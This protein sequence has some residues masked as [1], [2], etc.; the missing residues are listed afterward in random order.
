VTDEQFGKF[1]EVIKKLYV[2]IPLL[3]A[4]LGNKRTLPTT[5]VVQSTEKCSTA[6]LDPL[7]VNKKD[8]GCPT[9]TCS[10]G[11][12]HFSKAL[13]DLGASVSV[14]P[15]VVYDKL[16]GPLSRGNSIE[17]PSENPEFHYSHRLR[18][19]RHGSRRQDAAHPRQAILEHSKRP[20]RCR[21]GEILLNINGQQEKFAIKPKVEQCSQ[22][23]EVR[24]KKKPE[25]ETKKR[26]LP[27]I[28]ALIAFVE[29]LQIQEELRIQEE[30]KQIK[31]HNQRNA[32]RRIQRKKFLESQEVKVETQPTPKKV[33]RKKVSSPKTPSSDDNRTK[34]MESLAPDSKLEPSP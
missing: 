15:K 11:A 34:G 21:G 2:N 24:R 29:N 33:W 27:N 16:N 4:I 14:M 25:K 28:E 13:C 5:E 7:L 6:I 9:I 12:Q 26:S 10:I 20:H 19:T 30:A 18:R 1:V 23:K 3:T 31:L 8:P 32:K 22:V 17:Y